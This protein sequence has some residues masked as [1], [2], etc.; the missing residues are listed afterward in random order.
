MTPYAF[1]TSKEDM[2]KLDAIDSL[3]V[4]ADF[5]IFVYRKNNIDLHER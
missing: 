1:R 5:D 4:T 3:D 2:S